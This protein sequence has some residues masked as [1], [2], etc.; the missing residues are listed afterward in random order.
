LAIVL[1][2]GIVLALSGCVTGSQ[3]AGN[4]SSNSTVQPS[5][6]NILRVGEMWAI[7][8]DLL[9]PA[10][11]DG[12]FIDEK[13]GVTETLTGAAADF[14]IIPELATSWYQ[15]DNDTWVFNLRDDVY[16]HDGTKM[17][18]SAVKFSLDRAVSMDST[19]K[20]ISKISSISVINDTAIQ[21]TTSSENLMLPADLHYS[22]ASIIAKSSLDS[23]GNFSQPIGTGPFK[24]VSYN[25]QTQTV[26]VAK[27]TNYWNGT[28]GLDGMTLQ[29]MA[30]P[31]TRALAI[32]NGELD[33][34]VD[35]PYSETDSIASMPGMVVQKYNTARLYK[36]DL[37][38]NES[39]LNDTIVRQAIS[40][41]IDRNSIATN[42][43][44]GVGTPASGPFMPSM[45]WT[46]QSLTPYIRNVTL[47]NELLTNDGWVNGSDGI[48]EKNGV[49][50]EF[51]LMT[52][53]ARPGLPPMAEAIAA[54]LKDV[55]ISVQPVVMDT[56][57]ITDKISSGD[58]DMYLAAYATA[59][60]PDP[61]Y[62]LNNWYTTGGKD[63]N[64]G[65]SNPQLDNL[66]WTAMNTTNI[67]ERYALYDQAQY[68]VY[69]QQPK[70]LIAYYGCDIVMKNYVKGY[71]FDPTAHDYRLNPDMY[72]QK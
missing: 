47:A 29:G 34:T 26:T 46:N 68:I 30:D 10:Q 61:G 43:L 44:Y 64:G 7:T 51:T 45:S 72:I 4:T 62:I 53:T 17:N 2:V 35:V 71:Y 55:G 13:A 58:W 40:Y 49:K 65:Y 27:N 19:L 41:A 3:V 8:S 67:T 11:G 38:L 59:Q 32:E 69:D 5:N 6:S 66:I 25:E 28:V 37:N 60:V 50:L 56:G 22:D 21:I 36:I 23:N 54:E 15:V 20:G 33:F 31:N 57:A 52:Y 18:A 14:S 12:T 9:D 24:F 63:N 48:R 16:F 70:I 1:V 42:V 39:S